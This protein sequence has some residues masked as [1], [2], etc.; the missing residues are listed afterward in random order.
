[1]KYRFMLIDDDGIF[2][3]LNKKVITESGLAEEIIVHTSAEEALHNL[4]VE[5]TEG[6]GLPH[7]LF[8]DIR[9]PLMDGF[10]FLEELRKRP[11]NKLKE[12]SIFMLTSSLDLNDRAR[13][14]EYP[15]VK[16]FCTKN[17][18]RAKLDE[19]VASVKAS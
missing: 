8:L 16:G 1:M 11:D 10:E 5:I 4:D 19:C 18:D 15:Q 9:M 13:S 3:M 12:M 6:K 14:M 7:V 17:L 2:N